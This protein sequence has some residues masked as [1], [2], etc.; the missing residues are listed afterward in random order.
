MIWP[1]SGE[2][3]RGRRGLVSKATGRGNTPPAATAGRDGAVAIGIVREWEAPASLPGT[4][5]PDGDE[6]DAQGER[7]RA[8]KLEPACLAGLE[9]DP[10]DH[11]AGQRD[12]EEQGKPQRPA[13]DELD[14]RR[15]LSLI[16]AKFGF[17][18][19]TVSRG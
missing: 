16:A 15:A 18:R 7:E 4:R 17:P 3:G 1:R 8:G 13:Q 5:R 11:Q 10:V 2:P 14:R 12:H 6:D 19:A 9:P